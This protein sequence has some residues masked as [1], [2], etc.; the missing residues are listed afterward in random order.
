MY[1]KSTNIFK[2]NKLLK[3]GEYLTRKDARNWCEQFKMVHVLGAKCVSIQEMYSAH[4]C[5]EV[6]LFL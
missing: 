2:N 3:S 1:A 5:A 6:A 4:P